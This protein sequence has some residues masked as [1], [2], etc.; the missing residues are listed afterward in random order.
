M[1]LLP[2][3]FVTVTST[4]PEPGGAVA[5]IVV[6]LLTVNDVA[7]FTPKATAVAPVKL[8]PLTVTALPPDAPP[9]LGVTAVTAGA[10]VPPT[11]TEIALERGPSA[12]LL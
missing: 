3:G 4:D 10:G 6:A 2:P 11:V 9:V 8:L 1:A 12:V 5:V 7:R